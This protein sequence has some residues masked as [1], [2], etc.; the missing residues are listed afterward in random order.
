M[1][2]RHA[3]LARRLI[4]GCAPFHTLRLRKRLAR[5]HKRDETLA[6][7]ASVPQIHHSTVNAALEPI[8]PYLSLGCQADW[9]PLGAKDQV[10][11]LWALP[12]RPTAALPNISGT[13][14]KLWAGLMVW[15]SRQVGGANVEVPAKMCP[16]M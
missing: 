10:P 3:D 2:S 12:K 8:D 1:F 7:L 15:A 6:E 5:M 4:S 11:L 14:S 9:G 13:R 16:R